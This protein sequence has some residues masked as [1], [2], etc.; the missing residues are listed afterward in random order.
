MSYGKEVKPGE[1]ISEDVVN[2]ILLADPVEGHKAKIRAEY[3]AARSKKPRAHY[4]PDQVAPVATLRERILSMSLFPNI[5]QRPAH[6]R[7]FGNIM[8]ETPADLTEKKR[9]GRAVR[10]QG[11]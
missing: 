4:S 9:T 6:H 8:A 5:H 11:L 2:D 1:A 10:E 3:L 7:T